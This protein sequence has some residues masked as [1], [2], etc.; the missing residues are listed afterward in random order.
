MSTA[1]K[2]KRV[3]TKQLPIINNDSALARKL[4]EEKT[5]EER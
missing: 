5:F 3:G 1:L 2:P 4:H